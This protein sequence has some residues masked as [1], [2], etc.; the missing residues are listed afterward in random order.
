MYN[1]IDDSWSSVSSII[2]FIGDYKNLS[3]YAG[4]GHWNDYDM[5]I[6]GDFSLNE[7]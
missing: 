7:D 3:S 1:D 2:D 5:L 4:P 6:I